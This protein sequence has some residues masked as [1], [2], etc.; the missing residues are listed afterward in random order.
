MMNVDQYEQCQECGMV[1]V[2]ARV[3][4]LDR[5]MTM[6][7]V[8]HIGRPIKP[9]RR[10]MAEIVV[11]VGAVAETGEETGGETKIDKEELTRTV[12][13]CKGNDKKISIMNEVW[14]N[15]IV[16]EKIAT[17]IQTV[18]EGTVVEET[19]VETIVQGIAVLPAVHRQYGWMTKWKPSVLDG[20][21][22]T[23]EK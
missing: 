4:P 18:T 16:I 12:K 1:T 3:G 9:V 7:E 19:T 13:N 11:V 20:L 14:N 6:F 5:T 22:T 21:N 10:W 23:K 15:E 2:V 8:K 17:E